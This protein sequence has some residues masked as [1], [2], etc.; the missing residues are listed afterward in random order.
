MALRR[1]KK[2]IAPT[3]PAKAETLSRQVAALEEAVATE[4]AD[5]RNTRAKRLRVVSR[6][7]STDGLLLY[8]G[9][10][11]GFITTAGDVRVTLAAPKTSDE[12]TFIYL[13][14]PNE[15]NHLVIEAATGGL[16]NGVNQSTFNMAA[17]FTILLFCDGEGYWAD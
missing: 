4:T 13:W 14:S 7:Q 15:A 5:I 8:P 2:F 17:R 1:Q 11:A 3:D 6:N 16:I 12:G 10:A 9:D